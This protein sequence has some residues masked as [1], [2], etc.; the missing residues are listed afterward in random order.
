MGA[1]VVSYSITVLGLLGAVG[2]LTIPAEADN[3]HTRREGATHVRAP[4]LDTATDGG[5]K[6]REAGRRLV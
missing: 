4:T 3:W 1:Q 5:K 6:A 2:P